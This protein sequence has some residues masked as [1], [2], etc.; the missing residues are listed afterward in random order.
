MWPFSKKW[1]PPAP[2]LAM[3]V[4]AANQELPPLI[5]LANPAGMKGAVAGMAGPADQKPTGENMIMPMKEGPY[6]AI[7]LAGGLCTLDVE[8]VNLDTFSPL[9]LPPE[10]LEVSG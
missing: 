10:M 6:V 5:E 9:S 3:I 7:S 1:S 2:H 4:S 8:R